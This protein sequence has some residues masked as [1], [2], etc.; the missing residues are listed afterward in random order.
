MIGVGPAH[1]PALRT[2]D[3]P[4]SAVPEIEGSAVFVGPFEMVATTADGPEVEEIYRCGADG[5]VEASLRVL[6]DGFERKVRLA[7]R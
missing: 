5:T 4:C 1:A 6:D 3:W 2:S 7:R